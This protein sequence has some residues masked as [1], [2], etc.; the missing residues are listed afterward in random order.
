MADPVAPFAP[1]PADKPAEPVELTVDERL[2]AFVGALLL[3]YKH[4]API[5]YSDIQ[6]LQN[7]INLKAGKKPVPVVP[8][9]HP[10]VAVKP[11]P[12]PPP[13]EVLPHV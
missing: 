1:V 6:E 3:K 4:S 5:T 7:I 11:V 2:Q 12:T 10:T 9:A 13:V 8:V